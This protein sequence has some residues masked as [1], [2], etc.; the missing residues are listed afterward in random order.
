MR[1]EIVS[2]RQLRARNSRLA[3]GARPISSAS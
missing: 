2:H 3:L 1:W